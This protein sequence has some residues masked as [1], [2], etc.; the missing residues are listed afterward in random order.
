MTV[1][2]DGRLSTVLYFFTTVSI[3]VFPLA[4]LAGWLMRDDALLFAATQTGAPVTAEPTQLQLGISFLIGLA[5]VAIL[6]FILVLM[7]RLF[8]LFRA[9]DALTIDAGH[10]IQRIGKWFVVLAVVQFVLVPVQ[11]VL[12]SWGGAVGTRALSVSFTSDMAGALLAAGLLIVIGRAILQASDIAAE[13][14]E[15]I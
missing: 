10:V 3:V 5:P 15:F 6:V 11:S 12:L 1:T 2:P 8:A 14:K 9:G 13:N 7:R 4:V